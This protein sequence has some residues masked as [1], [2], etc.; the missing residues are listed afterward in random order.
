VFAKLGRL[1]T[2]NPWKVV[3][4]WVIAVGVIVPFS[5]TLAEVSNTDQTSFLPEGKESIRA[6]RLAE[7]A[8]PAA[9]GAGGLFVVS[10]EDGGALDAENRGQVEAL[11]KELDGAAIP[12][13]VDVTTSDDQLAKNGRVQLVS[14]E[15][16]GE[17]TDDPVHEA[18]TAIRAEAE[19]RLAGSGLVAG[20][21]GE[22][23]IQL[24]AEEAFG[25]AESITF[26]ATL[27]LIIVLVGAIFRSPVAAF[28]PILTIGLVFTVATSIVALTAQTF[29]F[30][31]DASLTSL[32]IVVLFGIG[33]DYILFLLFR[34]RERLRA[35]DESRAAVAFSVRR[36]GEAV[37]SSA[38]V[39]IAAFLALLLADLGFLSAMA[40][41]LAISVAVTL[42]ASLTLV[43][44]V[45]TLFGP[46]LFWPSKRWQ[47]TPDNALFKRLGQLIARRPGRTALVSG[48]TLAVLASGTAF[49]SASYEFDLPSGTESGQALETMQSAFPAGQSSPTEVYVR[50]GTAAE[51]RELARSLEAVPGVAS[52]GEPVES[53]DGS[54]TRVSATLADDP[55]SNAALATVEGPLHDAAHDSGAGDEVLVGGET[56]LVADL[57]DT[58]NRDMSLVFPVAA[59]II[60]LILGLLLRSVVAPVYLLAAVSLGFAA[61]LGA[62]VAIFQGLAGGSGLLFMLPIMLYLFV[63][64]IGTDYNILMTA[65]LREEAV[66]GN[67]PR[68]AADL[69]VEH[70]GP[71][72][73]AAGVIL[74]GTFAS[75]SLTGIGLLVQMGATIAIG[76]LLVS[77]VMANVF[78][79][80]LSALIGRRVWWPGHR[81]DADADVIELPVATEGRP[82]MADSR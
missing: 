50:G 18:I 33:T 30:E 24:D 68:T 11:A 20:L 1:V 40:P 69:S 32:L 80:S 15:F 60:A 82:G 78:V 79:P 43:P 37:A 63:V 34:Y 25:S 10:R 75:L 47:Q 71:T 64:A 44:A 2:A 7:E 66:E 31:V 41:G 48:L 26:L 70:A 57:R 38:L 36:V 17:S 3:L 14:V 56:A 22:A 19:S 46:R 61:T 12:H 49:Y 9:A 81:A 51:A 72:V 4:V 13:V 54:V 52:V 76:V 77:L 39:V 65:R 45:M 8:F 62:G 73:A 55:S 5:P 29:G 23:A 53:D 6:Q 74:A 21:T 42:L 58:V 27:L 28:L 67:D 16:E 35:G 59:L